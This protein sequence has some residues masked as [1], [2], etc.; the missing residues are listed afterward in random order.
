MRNRY[1]PIRNRTKPSTRLLLQRDGDVNNS[2]VWKKKRLAWGESFLFGT[3]ASVGGFGR[4]AAGV[5]SL[6]HF[7]AMGS[8]TLSQY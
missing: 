6:S 4:W 3:C 1:N 7:W 2:V 8:G 5:G